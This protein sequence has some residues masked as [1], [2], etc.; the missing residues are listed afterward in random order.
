[1]GEG[2]KSRMAGAANEDCGVVTRIKKELRA[3][4]NALLRVIQKRG[5]RRE[6]LGGDARECTKPSSKATLAEGMNG[7]GAKTNRI[8]AY[9]KC[10]FLGNEATKKPGSFFTKFRENVYLHTEDSQRI[11]AFVYKTRVVDDKT[12]FFVVCHGKGCDRYQ[13][14]YFG[15]FAAL[16][17]R[18]NVCIIMVDYRG[19]ADST[20]EYTIEGVNYDILAAFRHLSDVYGARE[21]SLVGHS[22]GT[23]V[24]LEYCRFARGRRE[25]VLP[26]K[27]YLIAP[28]TSTVEVCRDF[29]VFFIFSYL[30]PTLASTLE[31][32]FNYDSISNARHV[33]DRLFIFHGS[34]DG[35]ISVEHSRRIAQA[36]KCPLTVTDHDHLNIFS[37]QCT[38]KSIF[39][40]D[41]GQ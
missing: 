2:T 6:V 7:K 23:A 18:C 39:K 10:L 20:G 22:L 40:I 32:G 3:A 9:S 34:N 41:T 11:G 30:V 21:I 38:W 36:A 33:C 35:I 29:K 28:F 27:V 15:D 12:R 5:A 4:G 14:G 8:I 1:M 25:D 19:F 37:D 24:A 16:A 31:N 26:R 17:V 13:A